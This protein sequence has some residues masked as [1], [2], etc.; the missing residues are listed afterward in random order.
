MHAMN[1]AALTI[2]CLG[3]ALGTPAQA[4]GPALTDARAV[5]RVITGK[6]ECRTVAD[7][8]LC[9]SDSFMLSLQTDGTRTLR[10]NTEQ[11]DRGMQINIVLRVA[12]DLRPL[13][14]YT[15]TYSE[16]K[17]L[18]AGLFAINGDT[19]T[20]SVKTPTRQSLET[21]AVPANFSLLLHPV[22]ADGWHFGYYDMAKGGVQES[23]RCVVGGAR[24]SVRCA[25]STTPLEFV[26][27]ERITVPAGTFDTRR[28]KFGANTEVWLAG[29]DNVMVRH[30]YRTFGTR[31]QLVELKGEIRK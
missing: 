23:S 12:E 2:V 3:L 21:I 31:Y 19:L 1:I 11:P 10:A 15:L 8:K 14:G 28:F 30:D 27:N 29:R 18:G 5:E 7:D 13:E 17:F 24:E 20:A 26:A 22:S 25:M 9:G 6:L 16:G 4:Q